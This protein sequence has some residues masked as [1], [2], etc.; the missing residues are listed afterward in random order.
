MDKAALALFLGPVEL[1]EHWSALHRF[2]LM[3]AGSVASTFVRA[4][5]DVRNSIS[6]H[7]TDAE[8]T[9]FSNSVVSASMSVVMPPTRELT[10]AMVARAWDRTMQLMQL[11]VRLLFV[12]DGAAW[13]VTL[14]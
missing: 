10:Q 5:H 7:L 6:P 3:G 12:V 2:M 1:R 11:Q 9:S 13:R 14:V 4:L 8:N